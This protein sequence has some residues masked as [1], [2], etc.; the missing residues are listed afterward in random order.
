MRHWTDQRGVTAALAGER[1]SSTATLAL[2]AC[3]AGG[4]CGPGTSGRGVTVPLSTALLQGQPGYQLAIQ[5]TACW[6]GP[7]WAEAEGVVPPL[8]RLTTER[9]CSEVV[10]EIFGDTGRL[11]AFKAVEPAEVEATAQRVTKD[12]A[13]S[14][15]QLSRLVMH[16]AAA[17]RESLAARRASDRVHRERGP[18]HGGHGLEAAQTQ[19]NDRESRSGSA[20]AEHHDIGAVELLRAHDSLE[21]LMKAELG[22][23]TGDARALGLLI[24]LSRMNTAWALPRHLRIFAVDSVGHVI[25]NAPLPEEAQVTPADATKPQREGL[26]V[27]HLTQLAQTAGYPVPADLKPRERRMLAWQSLQKAIADRL[28][29]QKLSKQADPTLRPIVSA[30]VE[31]LNNEYQQ[32]RKLLQLP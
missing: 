3:L 8:Q 18:A 23:F 5:A 2:L 13:E 11:A 20:V 12:G 1:R 25:F 4:A 7:L 28:G 9:R 19:K 10:R 29:Q 22:D 17:Q 31:R 14:G 27:E 21:Q 6:F 16:V 30:E 26:L 24:G 15:A 32:A